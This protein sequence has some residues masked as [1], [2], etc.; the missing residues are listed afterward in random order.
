MDHSFFIEKKM[1]NHIKLYKSRYKEDIVETFQLPTKPSASNQSNSMF[2]IKHGVKQLRN[3]WADGPAYITQC[4][5]QNGNSYSY[6]F[7]I[8]GQRGTLWWHAHILWLRATVHGALVIMPPL[9]V[10]YPFPNQPHGEAEL[11]LG[12]WWNADVESIENQG[13]TLGLP[14]NMSDAHTI[15]GKPGP[16]FPCS[17]DKHTYALEVEWGKTYLLRIINAAL[18]DELFFAI[19]GHNMTV[20][21]RS[22][23]FI[24]SH[25]P[26][27]PSSSHRARPP[28]SSSEPTELPADTSWPPSC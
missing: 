8:T 27:T 21:S 4:P 19:A 2:E 13:N 17:Q 15:N 28:T 5:I 3:G 26:P 1:Q 6:D 10:P 22:M 9:G 20:W 7:N 23:R 12:E 11:V 25:S 14:P 18:N 24:A 16:L